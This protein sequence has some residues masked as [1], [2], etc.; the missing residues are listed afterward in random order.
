KN[1][2]GGADSTRGGQDPFF[3]SSS[4][5][6]FSAALA[7]F[8]LPHIGQDTIRT[9][10]VKFREYLEGKGWDTGRMGSREFQQGRS[11]ES[12]DGLGGEKAVGLVEK[13]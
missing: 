6:L 5:C 1:A 8:M 7:Y 10:D 9:E 2:P 13:V 12:M 11:L 3:V 4:L